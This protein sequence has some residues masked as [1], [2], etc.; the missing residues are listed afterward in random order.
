MRLQWASVQGTLTKILNTFEPQ[1]FFAAI[2]LCGGMATRGGGFVYGWIKNLE[3]LR[4]GD[5]FAAIF[6]DRVLREVWCG[7]YICEIWWLKG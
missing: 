3:L 2:F 1:N 7:R 4:C 6:F 5:F